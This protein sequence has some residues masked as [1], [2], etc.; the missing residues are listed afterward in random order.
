MIRTEHRVED[1]AN[2]D[3]L[4]S[5]APSLIIPNAPCD[6]AQLTPDEAEATSPQ[7]RESK[8]MNLL[9]ELLTTEESYLSDVQLTYEVYIIS[10]SFILLDITWC[11]R[12]LEMRY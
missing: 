5:P 1:N 8:Y 6:A 11:N 7:T 3:L 10:H 4:T 9:Q 2:T 12:R